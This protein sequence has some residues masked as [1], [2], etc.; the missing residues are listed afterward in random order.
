MNELQR[1]SA[2]EA[3]A[4]I[5]RKEISS[6]ELVEA[7]LA[8]IDAREPEVAAWACIDRDGALRQARE[9]DLA[10]AGGP[11]HGVP[12][13]VKDIIDTRD[14]PTEYGSPIFRGHRPQRDAACIGL[15]RRAGGIVLGKTV[16][17]EFAMYQ[18]GKT[19]N[20]HAAGHTPGGS[21]SGS[22]AAVAD[23]HVAAAFATQSSG[24]IIRPSAYC[25][26]VGYKP[27]INTFVP[28]GIKPLG[29]SLDTLGMITRTVADQ[30]LMWGVLQGQ[31]RAATGSA[32][33]SRRVGLCRTPYWAEADEGARSALEYVART[34]AGN[35]FEVEEVDL[36]PEFGSLNE[37]H[38]RI[39]AYEV[40]RN[41]VYE[42]EPSRRGMLGERT[43]QVMEDGWRISPDEY[44]AMRAALRQA[45]ARFSSACAGFS[46]FL[47]PSAPG[48][49]PLF[50]STGD[51]VFNRM[52]TLLGGPAVN[53]PAGRGPAGLP[54]GIQLVGDV[55]T[56][57]QLL[58]LCSEVE[59]LLSQDGHGHG[60]PFAARD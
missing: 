57:L 14:L 19:R 37:L 30:L 47:A 43:L 17:T 6:V 27:T 26:V 41:Y 56:D 3:A 18:P 44:L 50:A 48:E 33:Q 36:P 58:R 11:L 9:C 42:Y 23:F 22:A 55:D 49:A 16:T 52:W 34:L 12:V 32:T 38:G 20:P 2:S 4:A 13:G 51:P 8:R 5:A 46:A 28:D 35:G 24:S 53:L 59:N 40:S 54:V 25:G 7:C 29:A 60:Q 21:S 39:M 31:A 45:R 15:V 1:L 10:A